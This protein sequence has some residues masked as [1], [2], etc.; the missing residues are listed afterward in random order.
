MPPAA[1]IADDDAAAVPAADD[2]AAVP[3]ADDAAAAPAAD[4]KAAAARRRCRRRRRA[5]DSTP[6]VAQGFEGSDWYIYKVTATV[7]PQKDLALIEFINRYLMP[8]TTFPTGTRDASVGCNNT[9]L[10]GDYKVNFTYEG[11]ASVDNQLHWVNGPK[12]NGAG[13]AASWIE[14]ILE[15]TVGTSQPRRHARVRLTRRRSTRSWTTR[16]PRRQP[17]RLGRAARRR[18]R[19]APQAQVDRRARRERGAARDVEMGHLLI[20]IEGRARS[21]RRPAARLT[22]R[23]A[24]GLWASEARTRTLADDFATLEE[25]FAAT[26]TT[27]VWT[28]SAAAARATRG[29]AMLAQVHIAPAEPHARAEDTALAHLDAF[30]P[31]RSRCTPTRTRAPA[32]SPRSRGRRCRA[33]SSSWQ[34]HPSLAGDGLLAEYEQAWATEHARA[35]LTP[36]ATQLPMNANWDT[37]LDT[38]IGMMVDLG[39]QCDGDL[40]ALTSALHAADVAYAARNEGGGIHLYTGY[41]GTTSWEYNLGVTCTT[42]QFGDICTCVPENSAAVYE[43]R[44]GESTCRD[45]S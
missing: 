24:Y 39:T 22:S 20:P 3:A 42:E 12:L 28:D 8:G 29:P 40:A 4:D 16:C 15:A 36:S 37:F 5:D 23:G 13:L 44:F 27:T 45:S 2:A 6:G 25:R 30:T 21:A 41:E 10:G 26:A 38:H 9:H 35:F 33:S 43:R 7:R 17:R 31:P 18:P 14:T 34:R 32:A 19:A 11:T 1:A